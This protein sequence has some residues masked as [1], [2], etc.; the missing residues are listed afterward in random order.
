[1]K[2]TKQSINGTSFHST[3]IETTVNELKHILGEPDH[4]ENDGSDKV[5]FEWIMETSNG[6]VFTVYDW[7]EY[8]SLSENE[9]V[10]WHIG[11]YNKNVTEQAKREIESVRIL[12]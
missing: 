4:Y 9:V 3:V 5:N 11:G 7:K 10:E 2:K 6:D 8:R 12:G 1:M